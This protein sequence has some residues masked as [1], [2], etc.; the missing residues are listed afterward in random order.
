MMQFKVMLNSKRQGQKKLDT[1]ELEDGYSREEM[2]LAVFECRNKNFKFRER[3]R[4]AIEAT[5]TCKGDH[6]VNHYRMS[7]R[8]RVDDF[9]AITSI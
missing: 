3:K 2:N 8:F 5:V 9:G 1:F 7:P 4:G 6:S